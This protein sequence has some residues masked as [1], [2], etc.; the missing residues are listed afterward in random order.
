MTLRMKGM[1]MKIMKKLS[2]IIIMYQY[3]HV[4]THTLIRIYMCR[5]RQNQIS[6]IQISM[7]LRMR[8]MRMKIMKKLQLKE[9]QN[10]M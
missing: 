6:L 2:I 1:R 5:L 3:I 8:G 7:T 10:R 4:L 9:E